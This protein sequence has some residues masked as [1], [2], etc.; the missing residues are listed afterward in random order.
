MYS[1]TSRLGNTSSRKEGI[2]LHVNKN[3]VHILMKFTL[4]GV[5]PFIR[6]I[7]TTVHDMVTQLKR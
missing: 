4:V 7:I 6:L 3:R 2:T 5:G 1:N